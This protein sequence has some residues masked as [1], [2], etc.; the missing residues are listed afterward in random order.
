MAIEIKSAKPGERLSYTS[1]FQILSVN[2]RTGSMVVEDQHGQELTI[3]GKE[4]I[5]TN[6]K[7][8]AQYSTTE[9]LG[10]NALAEKLFTAGDAI[11]QVKFKKQDGKNRTLVG[12]FM[13]QDTNLGRSNMTDLEITKGHNLRQVDHRTLQEVIVNGVRYTSK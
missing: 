1:Y 6:M 2:K 12:Y 5:E 13:S 11:M 9:K 4:F 8:A 7:S 3:A 10:K